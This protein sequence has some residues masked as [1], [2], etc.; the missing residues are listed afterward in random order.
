MAEE[1]VL[2]YLQSHDEIPDSGEFAASSGLDHS[3]LL[4]VITSLNGFR[5]VNAKDIKREKWILT[6]EGQTYA[7]S[8]SP[9]VQFFLAIPP[10]G[11]PREELQRKVN[12]SVYKIGSSQAIKNK[13]VELGK[14]LVSRKVENVEDRVRELLIKIREGQEVDPKD[15]DALKKR[16]L[17]ALQTWKGYSLRKGPNYAP[18]R[19]KAA[20]DLT[21]EQLQ[22]GTWQGLEFKDYNFNAL[23]QPTEGGHLHPLLK[24]RAQFREIFL[25]MG[26]EEMPTNN[27]VESSF[28]NFDA[29]FQ[30]QQ[31]PARDSHDTFFS[32]SSCLYSKIA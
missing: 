8:G 23:G 25:E 5:L 7:N 30:P 2:G 11:I 18:K 15:V 31:H 12:G 14:L 22:K 26:F 17:I 16:K 10:E 3:E 1:A 27:F 21:R 6:E 20:T 32:E 9:E 24:V 19:M 13:W 28:W 4:S 29:L